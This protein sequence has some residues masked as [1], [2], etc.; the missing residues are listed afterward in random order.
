M[1][2][3][4]EK[5]MRV[6]SLGLAGATM[7]GTT[8]YI[9]TVDFSQAF[10]AVEPYVEKSNLHKKERAEGDPRQHS[11]ITIMCLVPESRTRET[12]GWCRMWLVPSKHMAEA[13]R[14]SLTSSNPFL[15]AK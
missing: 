12:D 5:E 8:K 1:G 14:I 3:V 4:K 2:C 6:G 13:V 11:G 10:W 9:Y 7:Y 15:L